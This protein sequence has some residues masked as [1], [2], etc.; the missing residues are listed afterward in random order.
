MT[1]QLA[2]TAPPAGG[3]GRSRAARCAALLGL[4][5]TGAVVSVVPVVGVQGWL[6]DS[7]LPFGLAG[8]AAVVL[9]GLLVAVPLLLPAFHGVRR[10]WGRD[11]RPMLGRVLLADTVAMLLLARLLPFHWG[12][13]SCL[14]FCLPALCVAWAAVV[15]TRSAVPAAVV[16]LALVYAVAVPVRGLQQHVVARQWMR[17]E[18]VPSRALAQV[19]V[20]PGM[21][22]E[23]YAWD[24][25]RLTALFDVPAGPTDAWLGAEVVTL[26]ST[27]PCGPLLDARGDTTGTVTPPCVQD[28]PGLWFRGTSQEAVG[29]VLQRGGVTI[30]LTGGVWAQGEESDAAY[31]ARRRA[32]LRE[33]ILAAH[34]ATDA[35]LASRV[36][37]GHP[38]LLEGLLR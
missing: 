16:V 14:V 10:T 30:A 3:A 35:E 25:T 18:A 1:A 36:R 29:Y 34:T 5:V 27:D 31:A 37:T 12:V 6:N 32:A 11:L 7:G 24:G 28:G 17:T 19:V 15:R 21:A 22:Q 4:A 8:A 23:R 13:L 20:L 33:V 2:Q 26:G 38:D 9:V